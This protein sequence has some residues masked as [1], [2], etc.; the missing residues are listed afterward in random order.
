MRVYFSVLLLVCLGTLL[1]AC[2]QRAL[3]NDDFDTPATKTS[4]WLSGAPGYSSVRTVHEREKRPMIVYFY[5]DWCG[6]CRSLNSQILAKSEVE[7][8]LKTIPRVRINPETGDAESALAKEFAI[9]GYPSFFVISS[10]GRR[11][12]ISPFVRRGD[13]VAPMTPVEFIEAVKAATTP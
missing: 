1:P 11:Q 7:E 5:T 4:T 10:Q 2:G 12:R 6:Y 8:F 3:T 13:R 9:T